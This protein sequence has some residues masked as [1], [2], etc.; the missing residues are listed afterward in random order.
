[1]H[2]SAD[3]IAKAK[4]RRPIFCAVGA[5]ALKTRTPIVNHVG[6]GMH[7]TLL[8]IAP[9][10]LVPECFC[11]RKILGIVHTTSVV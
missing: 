5:D 7:L 3:V 8:P 4:Y 9:F 2:K 1:M 11:L 6:H 10:T